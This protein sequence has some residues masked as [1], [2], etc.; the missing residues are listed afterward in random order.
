MKDDVE[1]RIEAKVERIIRKG[2]LSSTLNP[3][4]K[5]YLVVSVTVLNVICI[6]QMIGD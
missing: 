5:L 4:L 1:A 6:L 2:R 3:I